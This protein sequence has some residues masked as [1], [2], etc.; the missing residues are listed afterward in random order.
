MAGL[1]WVLLQP[2][3]Y[4]KAPPIAKLFTAIFF[5]PEAMPLKSLC[6]SIILLRFR[7][8]WL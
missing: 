2:E 1:Y 5:Y 8:I 7:E 4:S 3:L 6:S